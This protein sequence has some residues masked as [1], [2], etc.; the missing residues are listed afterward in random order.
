MTRE[1]WL[2]AMADQLRPDFLALGADTPENL[3]FSCGF[4]STGR[5]GKRIG[6]HWPAEASGDGAH[7]I[8]IHPQLDDP[9]R[10]ADVL[11]HELCHA[12]LPP[13]AKHG[14]EF[15][16]LATGM[17]LTGKM[18][19]TV[20]GEELASRLKALVEKVGPYPH[21]SLGSAAAA[22]KD[23]DKAKTYQ[24]KV[25]CPQCGCIVRMTRK[26]LDDKGA[27]FCGE[28]I[29]DVGPVRMVESV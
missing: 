28:C 13:G 6:E 10:V 19:A 15:R 21:A 9:I 24:L 20:A 22:A 11:V 2:K 14:K 1:G 3:R 5:R 17:G 26:W 29:D 4:P 8:F 23:Q 18:T 12:C 25:S 7:E 16:A 27:P